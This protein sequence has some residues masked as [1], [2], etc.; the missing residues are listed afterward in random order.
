MHCAYG[1]DHPLTEV[2]T[3]KPAGTS[4]QSFI[5][6]SPNSS[7]PSLSSGDGGHSTCSTG[8]RLPYSYS[9]QHNEPRPVSVVGTNKN[10]YASWLAVWRRRLPSKFR[11]KLSI[12]PGTRTPLALPH[13]A[14][15]LLVQLYDVCCRPM[16]VSLKR[17][18]HIR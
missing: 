18:V 16:T 1:R 11:H 12:P 15:T 4:W 2:L 17:H 6:Q 10:N 9:H 3:T 5:S 7:A 14:Y 13:Y 8:E